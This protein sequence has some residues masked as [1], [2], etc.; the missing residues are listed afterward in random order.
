MEAKLTVYPTPS[1]FDIAIHYKTPEPDAAQLKRIE[2]LR[3]ILKNAGA[4]VFIQNSSWCTD[5][6][7]NRFLVA[8]NNSIRDAYDLAIAALEWRNKRKPDDIEKTDGWA[9]RMSKEMETGKIYPS[10]NDKYGRPMVVF[11]NTVQNTPST[12]NHMIFLGWVLDLACREMPICCDKYVIFIHLEHFSLLNNPTL[13]E[14]KE[15]INM[16]C[17]SF[18]ERLGHCILYQPPWIFKG[19]FEAVKRFIDPKT[20]RKV[21]FIIGD[22]S[23]GSE[24]DIL[25][26]NLVG[27]H[28]KSLTG[29]GQSLYQPKSSPGYNHNVFWP[30]L[31][32]RVRELQMKE[33]LLT[34]NKNKADAGIIIGHPHYHNS[35]TISTPLDTVSSAMCGDSEKST[36]VVSSHLKDL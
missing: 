35:N 33:M 16:V 24:N 4:E 25:M 36:I 11:D 20:V 3:T 23:E 9:D 6:Q 8:K 21:V 18:P 5:D 30:L 7:L 22:D 32:N 15:T 29:A 12:D 2:E 14:T 34:T 19:V 13:S 31:M 27:N 1:S 10:G 17:N 26:K 28:W